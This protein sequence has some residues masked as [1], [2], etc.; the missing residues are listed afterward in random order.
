MYLKSNNSF[1]IHSNNLLPYFSPSKPEFQILL[2]RI[3]R[4]QKHLLAI[5]R[6]DKLQPDGKPVTAESAW[7]DIAGSPARFT[8]IVYMSAR[9]I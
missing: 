5:M 6:P 4:L 9:Y 2:Q 8:M 7:T 1:V 3:S